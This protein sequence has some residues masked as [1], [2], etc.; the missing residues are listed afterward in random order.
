[1][2]NKVRNLFR[3]QAEDSQ[4]ILQDSAAEQNDITNEESSS[5]ITNEAEIL[6]HNIEVEENS[7]ERFPVAFALCRLYNEYGI[8]FIKS[9]AITNALGD[10]NAFAN[11][12]PY[13]SIFK[14]LLSD[15][16]Y[17]SLIESSSET[18]WENI[19]H[20]YSYQISNQYG[21]KTELVSDLIREILIGTGKCKL[22]DLAS[23]TTDNVFDH[24]A[25]SEGK[26]DKS[27]PDN[28][29]SNNNI[30]LPVSPKTKLPMPSIDIF[31][32]MYLK[33]PD[34]SSLVSVKD[35]I[36]WVL[37][38]FGINP[39]NIDIVPGPRYSLYEIE[40]DPK[41]LSKISRNEKDIIVTLGGKG[42]RIV[43]L[44]PD[45][46]AI[47][48]EI[49]NPFD[50]ET[51]SLYDLFSSNEYKLSKALLPIALGMDASGLVLVKDLAGLN[52]LLIC[53]G[54]QQGKT[55]LVN[56]IIA[57]LLM[58]VQANDLKFVIANSNE[59]ELQNFESIPEIYL[60]NDGESD[61]IISDRP[62]LYK[63]FRSL[64]AEMEM[65]NGL[66]ST[67]GVKDIEDYNALF[68]SGKLNPQNGHHYLP[69]IVCIVDEIQPFLDGKSW[70]DIL[71]P[72]FELTKNTGVHFIFTTRYTSVNTLTPLIRTYFPNRLSFYIGLPNE[73][74][75]ILG[76]NGATNLLSIGDLLISGNG[77]IERCQS[78]KCDIEDMKSIFD[79]YG[80]KVIGNS[81]ILP[82]KKDWWEEQNES[83]SQPIIEKDPLFDEVARFVVSSSSASTSSIQRRYTIGFNRAGKIM[84]Q[85]ESAGIVGPSHGGKPRP[86]LV[87]I[88]TLESILNS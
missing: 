3:K 43:N 65:R 60:A 62:K 13:Q 80:H 17:T 4:E 51:I 47:G 59:L 42:C 57:S 49:P 10:Y 83:Y 21:F 19:V 53:G 23:Q 66:F 72:M 11:N 79:F 67:A 63:A 54:L 38:G 44:I 37:S 15:G 84:D 45:K 18:V 41:K 61:C 77:H 69:H 36:T 29:V 73:S 26:N 78:A 46:L 52:N 27:T 75:L 31:P 30:E 64:T 74:R 25:E 8:D 71:S 28:A 34:K 87:D 39:L 68:V 12:R 32:K 81:Y 6:E 24:Y 58:R 20:Q 50:L 40:V 1:M 82:E 55:S 22:S 35:R 2:F 56:Q 33:L 85:L 7:L 14:I 88:G 16:I 5:S 86:V 9:P 48:I 76:S 70:D